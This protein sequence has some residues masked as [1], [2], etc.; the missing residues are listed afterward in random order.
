MNHFFNPKYLENSTMND[1]KVNVSAAAV[2][3]F[4]NVMAGVTQEY[5]LA[6]KDR[7]YIVEPVKDAIKKEDLFYVP[8]TL[9]LSMYKIVLEAMN[10]NMLHPTENRVVT[11]KEAESRVFTKRADPA[12]IHNLTHRFISALGDV[13]LIEM[14]SL[15]YRALSEMITLNKAVI[16]KPVRIKMVQELVGLI[17]STFN[18]N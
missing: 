2:E 12:T 9:A 15:C 3:V 6:S 1:A 13:D 16:S 7:T 5:I 11:K 10:P 4:G 18:V 17:K 14:H 8:A